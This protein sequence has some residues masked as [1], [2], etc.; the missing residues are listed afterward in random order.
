[1]KTP[2]LLYLLCLLATLAA[3]RAYCAETTQL[4]YVV[5]PSQ[6]RVGDTVKVLEAG[7]PLGQI[8]SLPQAEDL[9]SADSLGDLFPALV[10]HDKIEIARIG[11]EREKIAQ[12]RQASLSSGA[13]VPAPA[14]P[15]TTAAAAAPE[16]FDAAKYQRCLVRSMD[17]LVRLGQLQ[18]TSGKSVALAGAIE[19]LNLSLDLERGDGT[20]VTPNGVVCG[21]YLGKAGT[22][23]ASVIEEIKLAKAFSSITDNNEITL[24]ATA[25]VASHHRDAEVNARLVWTYYWYALSLKAAFR[26]KNESLP[27][28]A[29]LG[30]QIG[31]SFNVIFDTQVKVQL[32]TGDLL[33]PT[34]AGLAFAQEL[35]NS[36]EPK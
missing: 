30:K 35:L 24:L 34:Q 36:G 16:A 4:R 15:V 19:T 9:P 22:P 26:Q 8:T 29:D 18:K 5:L 2:K 13:T 28:I 31:T 7:I 14:A 17:K 20:A 10:T 23:R 27:S 6:I 1:M 3:N 32:V 12:L 11:A 25:Y 33:K 21:R